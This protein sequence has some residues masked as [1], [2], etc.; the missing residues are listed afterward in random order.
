MVAPIEV[1]QRFLTGEGDNFSNYFS[2]FLTILHF[3]FT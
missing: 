3:V 1:N 2:M